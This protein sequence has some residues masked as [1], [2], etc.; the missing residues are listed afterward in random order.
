M[1]VIYIFGLSLALAMDAFA[2]SVGVSLYLGRADWSQSL[3]MSFHFGFFQGMMAALGWVAGREVLIYIQ[4]YDHWAAFFLLAV[5]GAKMIFEALSSRK[6]GYRSQDPTRGF[7]LYV[8][9]AAT[10][11]DALAA[12]MSI[13]VLKEPV[14]M[15]ALVI[16]GVAFI[17][18]LIAARTGPALG[19]LAGKGAEVSGGVILILIGIKILIEHMG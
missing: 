1:S 13:A 6:T 7:S 8:L 19:R 5:I 10:S 4:A 11:I 17:L 12:G 2:V 3:R 9:A 14:L 15:P 16:G 18:S